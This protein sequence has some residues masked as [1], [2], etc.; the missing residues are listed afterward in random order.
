MHGLPYSALPIPKSWA[1]PRVYCCGN[2]YK[3]LP[4]GEVHTANI[5]IR[6]HAKNNPEGGEEKS[7]LSKVKIVDIRNREGERFKQV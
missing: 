1:N 7:R 2:Q 6:F 3:Y 5:P 4:R